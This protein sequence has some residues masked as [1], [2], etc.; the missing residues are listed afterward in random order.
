MRTMRLLLTLAVLPALAGC[1]TVTPYQAMSGNGGYAEQRLGDGRYRV[2]FAGNEATSAEQVGDYLLRRAAELT[3]S[4]GHDWFRMSDRVTEGAV[5]EVE[6]RFGKVRIS[7]GPGYESWR[8]YGRVYTSSGF[9]LI[10][11]IWR[12]VTSSGG[13]RLEASAEIILGRGPTPR[14]EGT[15]DARTVLAE[16]S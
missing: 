8:N 5:R 14:E 6:T 3:L 16:L 10:G 12:S 13:E 1:A 4:E 9:G 2:T 11:P 15:F 7:R